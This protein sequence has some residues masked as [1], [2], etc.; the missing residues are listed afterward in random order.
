M[1][2][3][4]S[5]IEFVVLGYVMY[6]AVTLFFSPSLFENEQSNLYE[7]LLK[8]IP[9]QEAWVTTSIALASV[10][11]ISMF[12]K[13]HFAAMIANTL[14]GAF[15]MMICITYMFIYPN[16]GAGVF[17]FVSLGSF[18]QV[19]KESNRYEKQKSDTLRQEIKSKGELNKYEDD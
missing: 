11:V 8:L 15:S 12:I 4:I 14:G 5:T 3:R 13:H 7:A 1:L 19:Y 10:Y 6:F 16:I 18:F 9:S 2:R 17:L